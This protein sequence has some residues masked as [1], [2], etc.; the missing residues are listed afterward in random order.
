MPKGEPHQIRM[1][2]QRS[3]DSGELLNHMM[4]NN[5]LEGGKNMR[6]K[7]VFLASCLVA[8]M[9]ALPT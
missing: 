7:N 3:N 2:N 8:A 5:Y 1:A 9:I 4:A 6:Y